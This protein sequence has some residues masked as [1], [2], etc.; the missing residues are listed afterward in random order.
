MDNTV[1]KIEEYLE[2][3]EEYFFSSLSAA[4]TDLPN[5]HEA[6]NR[7]WVDI[8]RY[9][10]GLPAFPEVRLPSL[11]DFQVPPP[12]PPPPS[13]HVTWLNQSVHWAGQHPWKVS[14]IAVG[15]VGASLL[16]G[17]R[18]MDTRKRNR[19]RVKAESKE[20]RQV[21]VVLGGDTPLALPL[22]LGLEKK[23]YIVIASVSTPEAVSAL[24]QRCEGYVR[25][26]VLDPHEPG[27][28]T[29]FLRSL[30]ST[31]SRKFPITS[32]GDPFAT[33]SAHPYIHSVIS[34]L[35]LPT[36]SP[37]QHAP[38][39]HLSLRNAYLPYLN[40]TH[41]VPLQVIQALLPLLRT[42]P[43]RARD[44][45]KKS[46]IV[47]L[48]AMDAR[49]G[50]PF[51][52]IQAMSAAS[53]LRAIEVLR[54]EIKIAALTDKT[55]S[56]KNIRVVIAD[57]GTF[58][59]GSNTVAPE[60]VYELMEDWSP[61]EKVAYGPAFAALS[62]GRPPPAARNMLSK[63]LQSGQRYGIGRRPTDVRI[64]VDRLITEVNGAWMGPSVFGL[65]FG[66]LRMWLR[67]ER[68]VVGAGGQS[69]F[70]NC[71]LGRNADLFFLATTYRTASHLP[72]FIL[73]TILNIPHFLISVRNRL[74]PVE[75]FIRPN[76]AAPLP[77]PVV[78]TTAT[79]LSNQHDEGLESNVE[80]EVESNADSVDS[81]I[82]LQGE[83]GGEVPDSVKT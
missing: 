83:Q 25:A 12:P 22:I 81:W 26:L 27:T 4:T 42:G 79:T 5:I 58:D 61:S 78:E 62:H 15:V 32:S 46:I 13:T 48:P 56:M 6:V 11:G 21:V 71:S 47:C 35:T 76:P 20:R 70:F 43:A 55:E 24:E 69:S 54:R 2:S 59:V 29:V 36:A 33:P 16:V 74:L 31:L 41:I 52:S 3:L 72:S 10:P 50:L 68:F 9:G 63:W 51:S 65:S 1:E 44:K 19:Y 30:A 80:A 60:N 57:V 77:P 66:T 39:E 73:D 17:Y 34:L 8:A 14:G 64:F 38:L 45:G 75:P 37:S 40:A 53:T 28:T 18:A 67:G 49:V 23:G 7:L 82:S